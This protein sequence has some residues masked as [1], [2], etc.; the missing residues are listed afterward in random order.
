M[1][2]P[3]ANAQAWLPPLTTQ[4]PAGN[5]VVMIDEARDST[6]KSNN[7][8]I[9]LIMSSP[10]GGCRDW[11]TLAPNQFSMDKAV[12]LFYAAGVLGDGEVPSEDDLVDPT[13]DLRLKPAFI[14]KLIGRQ[15]G[16]VIRDKPDLKD[17]TQTRP[18][19]QGYRPASD[20]S[21]SG[22]LPTSDVTNAADLAAFSSST[23]D[24]D[25]PF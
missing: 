5:F 7:P 24:S 2:N 17:P 6:S 23:A 3:F 1:T 18:Q 8:Q 20:I 14:A 15:V 4:L 22:A 10:Q 12:G 11:V 25:L 9:E 16:V 13:V 21:S 19:V